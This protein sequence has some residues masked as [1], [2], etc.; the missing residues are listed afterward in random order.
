MGNI[1][2]KIG[3]SGVELS[4]GKVKFKDKRI[5]A[6]VE[7]D[8]PKKITPFYVEFIE[9]EFVHSEAIVILKEAI[10][11]LLILDIE[12]CENRLERSDDN[13]EKDLMKK[14]IEQ[15]ELEIPL[16]DVELT[17]VEHEYLKNLAPLSYKPVVI[18]E[19]SYEENNLIEQVLNKAKVIFF[20]T[21][22]PQE[23]HAWTVK[24]DSNII[25]CAGKI[26]TDLARGFI[27][28]DVAHFDDYLQCH[29]FNDGRKKGLVK[30]VDRDHVV[31]G[32]DVIE[33]RF[34]V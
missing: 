31:Q 8:K 12:K 33:I 1:A 23:V 4:D 28:G 21:S 2:L 14:C 3:F 25:A 17:E 20:Y 34:N 9:D 27:K 10:L 7:K 26:H 16:C 15:L 22:G 18:V 19:G 13:A 5:D 6:L 11:D 24:K 30:V 32:G 29:N